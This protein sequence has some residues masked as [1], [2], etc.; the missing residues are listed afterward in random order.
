MLYFILQLMI[1]RKMDLG[2]HLVDGFGTLT[3]PFLYSNNIV[4]FSKK[5]KKLNLDKQP[6]SIIINIIN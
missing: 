2:S 5:T 3:F 4:R 6:Q 1:I